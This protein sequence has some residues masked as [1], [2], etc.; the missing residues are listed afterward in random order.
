MG[1]V[2]SLHHLLKSPGSWQFQLNSL[3]SSTTVPPWS[4]GD[5]GPA[6]LGLSLKAVEDLEAVR[7]RGA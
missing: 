3:V 6:G 5:W 7:L 4:Q 2:L 1:I